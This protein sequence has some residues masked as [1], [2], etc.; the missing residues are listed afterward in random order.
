MLEEKIQNA[1]QG[2]DGLIVV[3]IEDYFPCAWSP[4]THE[5]HVLTILRDIAHKMKMPIFLDKGTGNLDDRERIARY[6]L[7][8]SW[9]WIPRFDYEASARIIERTIQKPR[10]EIY[11]G[12]GG[13]YAES[14]VR[15]F[16]WA[17]CEERIIPDV[18]LD[19]PIV[20]LAEKPIAQ[21]F[22]KGRLIYELTEN[23]YASVLYNS[24][25]IDG[26]RGFY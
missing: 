15:K 19:C 22:K 1:L 7:A 4:R 2:I 3:D 12:F 21:Q 16:L 18:P 14:C 23:R 10:N 25:P 11:L 13:T 9:V 26:D 6:E 8:Q 20:P 24:N 5:Y 17:L